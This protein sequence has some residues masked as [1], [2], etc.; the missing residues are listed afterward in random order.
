MAD[1][2]NSPATRFWRSSAPLTLELG[3]VLP[4]YTLAYRTWGQL[5]SDG[6]NAVIVC[7]ALTGTADADLW[8]EPLF[9]ADKALDPTRDFIVCSNTLGGC[10]GSSGAA[11]HDTDGL[12]RG[13]RFPALTVRDQVRA[14]MALADALGIKRIKLVIGGSMGGLQTLEWALLDPKRV[15]AIVVIAAS[16]QHSAWCMTWS[17]AQRMSL[18]A[19][20]KFCRGDYSRDDAPKAGLGAAR[21]TAMITY[22]SPSALASRYGRHMGSA[23]FGGGAR[24][25]DDFAVRG[26]MRHHAENFVNRFDA[27][28]YLTLIDAM[29]RHDVGHGRGG[30]MSALARIEQ[31]ALV[32]AISSDGLYVPAEQELLYEAMPNAQWM[33]LESPHGHDAFLIEAVR[34]EPRIARFR[35]L[36]HSNPRQQTSFGSAEAATYAS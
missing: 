22:R 15:D 1:L 27:N 6:G 2:V 33:E 30:V 26:W 31:P 11:S 14:Q 28:C 9:G 34:L 5:S 32:V 7:H 18:R 20:P 35:A 19:D 24:H 4:S 12:Y 25:P 16:A 23:V 10:Y 21:A 17:E 3:S 13:S 8:W 29:D 36:V